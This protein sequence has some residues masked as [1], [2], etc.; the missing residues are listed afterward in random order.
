MNSYVEVLRDFTSQAVNQSLSKACRVCLADT[1]IAD[2]T[3]LNC[4]NGH[5]TIQH[6][7]K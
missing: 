5:T 6:R 1:D 3:N 4:N 7:Q 2:S